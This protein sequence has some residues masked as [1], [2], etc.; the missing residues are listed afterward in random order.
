MLLFVIG[1]A[2]VELDISVI[3]LLSRRRSHRRTILRLLALT[4]SSCVR[5]GN[6]RK[7][8][9][10]L[11]NSTT[12]LRLAARLAAVLRNSSRRQSRPLTGVSWAGRR[13]QWDS[14]PDSRLARSCSASFFAAAA[15]AGVVVFRL[16][17]TAEREK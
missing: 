1:D 9:S 4:R 3:K 16:A 10:R 2:P 14:S 11:A 7:P 12:S 5:L 13:R 15:A 6:R 8:G 17:L